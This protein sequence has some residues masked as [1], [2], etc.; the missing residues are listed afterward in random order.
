MVV[1]IQVD[2][3]NTYMSPSEKSIYVTHEEYI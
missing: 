2:T 1:V 3:I